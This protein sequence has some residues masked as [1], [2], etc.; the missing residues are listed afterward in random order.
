MSVHALTRSAAET[1]LG[2]QFLATKQFGRSRRRA[3]AFER[4]S[5]QGLPT[6]RVES[7]HYTDLRTAM[8]AAAPPASLPDRAALEA[9]RTMIA[10]REGVAGAVRIVTVDG[11]FAPELSDPMPAGVTL[12]R[13]DEPSLDVE[14]AMA[15]LVAAM[16]PEALV[17]EV[18]SGAQL[19]APVE[20]LR[21]ATDL[22]VR[23]LYSW[24]EIGIGKEAVATIVETF[25]G[26]P[27]SVQRHAAT[28][29]RL[30]EAAR[31]DHVAV[32]D[33]DPELHVESQVV[34]LEARAEL[35]TFGFVSGGALSRRQIFA[36][37]SGADAKFAYAGLALLDGARQGDT[38][39]QVL[40]TA[41]GGVSREYHRAIVA[42]DAA[43]VFQGKVVVAPGAQKT[44]GSMKSQAVLLSPRAQMNA[45]PEL[46]IFA[47]DVVCGHGATVAS[48]DPEQVFYLQARG[49]A[50]GE[51]EALLLEAFGAETIDKI[52]N[53]ALANRLR[54][55]LAAWLAKRGIEGTAG[56]EIGA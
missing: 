42:D 4:F 49:L 48:I 36:R 21:V 19:A 2:E 30:A 29:V 3:A 43:G 52:R 12:S 47:D 31:L 33:D 26:A 1:A 46:E 14:D 53:D 9:A 50:K 56:K 5:A 6:R 44:D 7:W 15:S 54:A 38:T 24:T 32:V 28:L 13:R 25:L 16:A 8:A 35:S 34:E 40:H 22:A 17:V 39:L 55:R 37:L 27:A 18:A 41:R 23:S 20:I 51:A 10:K 11:A 45:K